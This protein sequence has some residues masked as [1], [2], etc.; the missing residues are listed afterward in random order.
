M[1]GKRDGNAGD[2]A[3]ASLGT[4]KEGLAS[5]IGGLVEP[6][7]PMANFQRYVGVLDLDGNSW[8]S[9]FRTLLCYKSVLLKVEPRFVD[10]FYKHLLPWVHYIPVRGNVSDLLERAAY[11]ADPRN[12]ERV[13]AIAASA[14]AWCR[15]YMIHDVLADE[16]LVN[17][18]RYVG[19]LDRADP[20]W[21]EKWASAKDCIFASAN[22]SVASDGTSTDGFGMQP[23]ADELAPARSAPSSNGI[24]PNPS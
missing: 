10:S 6:I 17:C 23:V 12:R 13:R 8:R 18:A 22:D 1:A 20:Q 3:D 15:S 21:Q 4:G 7:R 19:Y 16:V 24:R 9:R 5:M 2:V 14:N 11:V